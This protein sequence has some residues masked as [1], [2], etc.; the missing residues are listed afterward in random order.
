MLV[1]VKSAKDSKRINKVYVRIFLFSIDQKV[2]GKLVNK[3]KTKSQSFLDNLKI[4][5]PACRLFEKTKRRQAGTRKIKFL[6]LGLR[7]KKLKELRSN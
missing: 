5:W 6:E 4:I 7:D 1:S 2:K 3:K